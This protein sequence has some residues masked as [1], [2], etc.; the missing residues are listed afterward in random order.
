MTPVQKAYQEFKSID[1]GIGAALTAG[2]V[3]EAVRLRTRKAVIEATAL[4]RQGEIE[5]AKT[6]TAGASVIRSAIN[7]KTAFMSSRLKQCTALMTRRN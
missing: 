2:N 3:R 4:A 5:C 1:A 6:D 7:R